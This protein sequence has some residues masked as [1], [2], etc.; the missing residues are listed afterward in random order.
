MNNYTDQISDLLKQALVIAWVLD[1][2][3]QAKVVMEVECTDGMK[4]TFNEVF[5]GLTP[6][7]LQTSSHSSIKNPSPKKSLVDSLGDIKKNEWI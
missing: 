4:M 3:K 5:E 1:N 6:D 7:T 2:F